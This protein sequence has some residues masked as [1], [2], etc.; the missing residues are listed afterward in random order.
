M[1][2]LIYVQ[3]KK[4]NRRRKN[5]CEQTIKT[6]K[7]RQRRLKKCFVNIVAAPHKKKSDQFSNRKKNKN[8]RSGKY[9]T[10]FVWYSKKKYIFDRPSDSVCI[11]FLLHLK[12]NNHPLPIIYGNL[13]CFRLMIIIQF[14]LCLDA[15]WLVY[16]CQ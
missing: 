12:K 6:T 14:N 8:K 4:K 10:V 5:S 13:F 2:I 15:Y 11:L 1:C 16:R 9:S 7:E 3:I